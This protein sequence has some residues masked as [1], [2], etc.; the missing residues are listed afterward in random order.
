MA[1]VLGFVAALVGAA[2]A[3][4]G[5]WLSTRQAAQLEREKWERSN[6]DSARDARAAAIVELTR[7]LAGALQTIVW[8]TFDAGKRTHVFGVAS[9]ER[10]DAEM[11]GHL[12]DIIKGLVTVAHHDQSA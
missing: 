1:I 2:A 3:L 10:Y 5:T 6:E 11:L 9:V 8:F 7:N 12:T 4:I